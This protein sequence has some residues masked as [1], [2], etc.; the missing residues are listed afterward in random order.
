GWAGFYYGIGLNDRDLTTLLVKMNRHGLRPVSIGV[1]ALPHYYRAA[2]ENAPRGRRWTIGHVGALA[3]D[4][5]DQLAEIGACVT[6]HTTR[7]LYKQGSEFSNAPCCAR[8][9]TEGAR[10]PPA[11]LVPLRSLTDRGVVAAL[12]TDNVPIS[13]FFPIWQAVARTC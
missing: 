9:A 11:E 8:G 2:H 13:M 10:R 4:Q 6:T 5:I 7:F 1:S 12:G 3:H